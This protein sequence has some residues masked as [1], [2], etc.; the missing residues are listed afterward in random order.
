VFDVR[1]TGD[2]QTVRAVVL[3]PFG[4]EQPLE[5]IEDL[6]VRGHIRNR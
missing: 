1:P 4:L 6:A 2:L 3:E 5:E